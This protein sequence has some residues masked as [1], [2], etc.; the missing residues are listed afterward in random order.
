MSEG[1][2]SALED[3]SSRVLT[4]EDPALQEK[5]RKHIPAERIVSEAQ[6]AITLAEELG[7]QPPAFQDAVAKGLLLWFK[8]EFFT[9]VNQAPCW[10]CGSSATEYIAQGTPS[11]L[12]SKFGANRVEQYLCPT[13]KVVTEFPRY[14]DAEKLLET[15]KG[16]CG[17]WANAFTLC[18]RAM[19]LEARLVL[20]RTDHV[21]TEYFS[22]AENRWVHLDP[23]EAAYDQPL[24]YESGWGKKLTYN[25]GFDRYGATDVTRRYTREWG[26]VL[27][28][29]VEI[30]EEVLGATLTSI[31]ARRRA[32]LDPSTLSQLKMRDGHEAAE[33]LSSKGESQ[34]EL[35]G[36]QTGSEEWRTSRGET[37]SSFVERP[38]GTPFRKVSSEVDHPMSS[39][40]KLLSGGAARAS[41]EN[42]PSCETCDK[43]FDGR[44][45]TKWLDFG[46]GGVDGSAWLEYSLLKSQGSAR[47]LSY[48]LVS[49]GDAPERDPCDWT[50]FGLAEESLGWQAIAEQTGFVFQERGQRAHF[51]VPAS[52]SSFRRFKLQVTRLRESSAANSV[53][54][55][56][57]ELYVAEKGFETPEESC[58]DVKVAFKKQLAHEFETMV[59]AG[60]GM[61]E[62]IYGAIEKLSSDFEGKIVIDCKDP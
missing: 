9:W 61:Q 49:A 37:G 62:A 57:L 1:L 47:L 41:G 10:R 52:P 56:G 31:T 15:R 36:R 24:L 6:E 39:P 29:R 38:P 51:D 21:W 33:L 59:R 45:D 27:Q 54:L 58:V 2:L 46:G 43:A 20:D 16:R 35:P 55:A 8:H 4:Y 30:Q 60:V 34:V 13:C 23:C 19:G 14:N 12:Q 42:F 11:D 50:F 26:E 22:K 18:C 48:A 44:S 32:G 53:Q 3:Y 28:R 25:I 5:A 17:E 40:G 7:G